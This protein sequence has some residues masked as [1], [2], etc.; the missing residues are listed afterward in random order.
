[1]LRVLAMFNPTVRG[2]WD[3]HVYLYEPI[4]TP[5]SS[6]L[7][8]INQGYPL[9]IGIFDQIRNIMYV[10][11]KVYIFKPTAKWRLQWV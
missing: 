9:E 5:F 10:K 6:N 11:C 8:Y 4:K 3:G 2:L 7:F 1:M